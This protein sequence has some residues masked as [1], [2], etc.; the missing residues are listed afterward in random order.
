M[1]SQESFKSHGRVKSRFRV[2]KESRVILAWKESRVRV[3]EE[4][5]VRVIEESRVDLESESSRI[6]GLESRVKS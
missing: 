6:Q 3:I 4:S 5:R 2:T 1:K